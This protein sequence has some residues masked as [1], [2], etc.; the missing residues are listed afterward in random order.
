MAFTVTGNLRSR[1]VMDRLGMKPDPDLF[2]HPAVPPGSPL[3]AHVLYRIGRDGWQAQRNGDGN[4][5][6]TVVA[7]A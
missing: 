4:V 3:R 1:A 6:G 5:D 7:A 2:D